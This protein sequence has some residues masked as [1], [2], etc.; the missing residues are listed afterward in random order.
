MENE[1][2]EFDDLGI[3]I[4]TPEE[5]FLTTE[6]QAAESALDLHEKAIEANSWLISLY[7]KRITEI[8]D[9]TAA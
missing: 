5:A 3:K 8:E 4:G 6:L 9:E 2:K 7:K 1:E